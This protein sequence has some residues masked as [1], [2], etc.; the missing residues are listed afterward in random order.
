MDSFD[1]KIV[2][3]LLIFAF[4]I[5]FSQNDSILY[6]NYIV[7][8]QDQVNKDL[9][10]CLM[11]MNEYKTSAEQRYDKFFLADAYYK[12][13]VVYYKKSL[14]SQVKE[15]ADESIKYAKLSNNSSVLMNA[16]NL[17]GANYYNLGNLTLAESYYSKKINIAQTVNDSVK[18]FET[19]YN[20]GLIYLQRGEYFK[21]ADMNFKSLAY[22]E[23]TKDTFNLT[24]SL[25]SI[26]SAYRGAKDY[27][28]ALKFLYKAEKLAKLKNY[29]YDLGGIYNDI[30]YCYQ[31][32]NKLDSV[33]LN[34]EFAEIVSSQ[35]KDDFHY[36]MTLTS[37]ASCLNKLGRYRESLKYCLVSEKFNLENQSEISLFNLYGIMGESYF[38]LNLLD[39][40]LIANYKGNYYSKKQGAYKALSDNCHLLSTIFEKKNKT[41]SALK[42]LKLYVV[43]SDST[44]KAE[45]LR[46]I[47]QK[48]FLFEKQNQENLRAKEKQ[49]ASVKLAQ[50]KRINVIVSVASILLLVLIIIGIINYKQKQKANTLV[51]EQKKL[52]EHKQKEIIDSINYAK[53]IQ[54][55]LLPTKQ[56]IHKH[57]K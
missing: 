47:S 8:Y 32:L 12:I 53:R 2:L 41:D 16:Y 42:Y 51:L 6:K 11:K 21:S 26:G 50:Q 49:L 48:E 13:A 1:K 52:L 20:L 56:Y 4:K 57:L 30:A 24:A 55:A 46:G 33:W 39:S 10:K 18:E 45:Q 9:D 38:H 44:Q 22:F 37:K 29:S 28:S 23:K 7:A 14:F 40:A 19:Y 35:I 36:Y 43:F 54:N 31:E 15:Y 25:S 34:L 27:R 3:I 5:G 17:I